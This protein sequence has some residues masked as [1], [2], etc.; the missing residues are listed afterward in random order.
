MSF[1][2]KGTDIT[3]IIETDSASYTSASLDPNTEA[4]FSSNSMTIRRTQNSHEHADIKPN[5]FG[6]KINGVDLSSYTIAKY[7]THTN[8]SE[9]TVT[10]SS[11][12]NGFLAVLVGGGGGGSG[13]SSLTL[14][15]GDGNRTSSTYY[16]TALGSQ[17]QDGQDGQ[18]KVEEHT[19]NN[20]NESKILTI[21][22]GNAGSGGARGVTTRL[23]SDG[24]ISYY[25]DYARTNDYAEATGVPGRSGDSGDPTYIKVQSAASTNIYN[26]NF[27][28]SG[29]SGGSSSGY[30][31]PKIKMDPSQYDSKYRSGVLTYPNRSQTSIAQNDSS[32]GN[33]NQNILGIESYGASG[34]GG[35]SNWNYNIGRQTNHFEGYDANYHLDQ[36]RMNQNDG[37]A[38]TQGYIRI[39]QKF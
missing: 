29:G 1:Q 25:Y 18:V 12:C 32:Y 19:F 4:N 21:K 15:A 31:V 22:C 37:N 23:H 35:E 5:P 38:G 8:T 26:A 34:N 14:G 2:Y 17:G 28:A 33:T 9:S 24:N 36:P 7:D 39:Y 30:N 6:Y 20:T 10:L 11:N 3:D 27:T 16:M 13:A